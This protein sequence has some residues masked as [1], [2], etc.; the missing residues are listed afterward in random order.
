MDRL[1]QYQRGTLS[2]TGG[3]N[4]TGGGSI[5]TAIGVP[6]T[7]TQRTYD[8]DGLGNWRNTSFT[9]AGG[10]A[11]TEIR[12]HNGLNQV[13]RLQNPLAADPLIN[14]TYDKNGNLTADGAATYT[15]DA[16]NRLVAAG[17]AAQYVYDALNRRI[18][19]TV[20]GAVTDCLYSGWRCVEDRDVSNLPSIQ[21]IWGIYL[22]EIIQQ[23]NIA[24][25]SGFGANALLYPLQDLLYRTTGLSDSSGTVREAYDMDAYGNTLIFRNSGSPPSPI[26]FNDTGTLDTQVASPTCPFIFTGQ[27]FDAETGLYYYRARFY[28]A[29]FGRFISRDPIGYGPTGDLYQY[30]NDNP[31]S[32][33]D[34]LG[35]KSARIGRVGPR[36]SDCMSALTLIAMSGWMSYP[37]AAK[38]LRYFLKLDPLPPGPVC[39]PECKTAITLAFLWLPDWNQEL[40]RAFF[41]GG[42]FSQ[43][44]CG[45]AAGS[46]VVKGVTGT[47]VFPPGGGGG[48]MYYAIHTYDWTAN[49]TNGIYGCE[50]A[51]P[52]YA[53]G[54]CCC[55]CTASCRSII[56]YIKTI[57]FCPSAHTLAGGSLNVARFSKLHLGNW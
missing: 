21:Y 42:P 6:N 1:R 17:S 2:T 46:F 50:N 43:A 57:P 23:K 25:I 9:P 27:R 56:R 22:D 29:G 36:V 11:E 18:R 39:P 55:D 51:K 48:D 47:G 28:H 30:T 10:S 7:D 31:L 20:S 33:T 37:C 14:P 19:K 35:L 12:Q 54:Q 34:P 13:T 53:T 15:W 4:N 38:L 24:A 26:T 40:A 45:V 41:Q 44:S 16:L 8:L 3:F 32:L 49:F 52:N 5:T